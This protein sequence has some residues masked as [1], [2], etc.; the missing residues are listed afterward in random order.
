MDYFDSN[1]ARDRKVQI[2][3]EK[4]Y[5]VNYLI[6]L[7]VQHHLPTNPCLSVLVERYKIP[8][9]VENPIPLTEIALAFSARSGITIEGASERILA[10]KQE[11]FSDEEVSRRFKSTENRFTRWCKANA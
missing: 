2:D 5:N 1:I 10:T 4:I 9:I 7:L 8:T 11:Y 3:H 6:S